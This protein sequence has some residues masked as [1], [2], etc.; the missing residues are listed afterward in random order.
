LLTHRFVEGT[1]FVVAGGLAGMIVAVL[2]PA[3]KQAADER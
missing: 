3:P 2:L 1:W